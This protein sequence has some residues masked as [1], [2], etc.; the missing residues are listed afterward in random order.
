MGPKNLDFN[1]CTMEIHAAM[2][3]AGNY[4]EIETFEFS[5]IC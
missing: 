5:P 3:I 1:I 2:M 4:P